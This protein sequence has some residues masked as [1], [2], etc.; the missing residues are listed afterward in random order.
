MRGL[1]RPPRARIDRRTAKRG[2]VLVITLVVLAMMSLAATALMRA[3]DTATA[4]A[5]NLA[6]REASIPPANAAIEA[7]I[8]ALSDATVIADRE[9][10]LPAQNYYASR[11]PGED[12]RGV[13][14]LLQQPDRYP[15]EAR[16]PDAGDGNTLHYVIERICLRPGSATAANCALVQPPPAASRRAPDPKRRLPPR[17]CFE[18]RSASTGRRTRRRSCRRWCAIPRR[19]AA[20]PG[21]SSIARR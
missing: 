21:E 11:Q 19:R 5:G 1:A 3:V 12:S 7:A 2:I 15:A 6:F 10:D 17:A 18:S 8:A 16:A 13:P 4:V 14:W 20:C 9:R